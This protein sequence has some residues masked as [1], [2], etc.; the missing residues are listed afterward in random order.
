MDAARARREARYALEIHDPEPLASIEDVWTTASQMATVGIFLLL[1]VACLYFCRPILL[2]ILT[3]LLIGTTFA[4]VIKAANARGVSPWLSAIVLVLLG[5]TAAGISITMLAAPVSEWI[6]RAPEIG[7]SIKEKLYVFDRPLAAM[8][9]L[10]QVLMPSS[11]NAVAVESSQISGVVTPVLAFVT[12][13]VAQ[14][15]LFVACLVFFLAAQ[16]DARR[17]MVSLFASREGKLR[18]IR[19]ANDIEHNLASYVAVVSAINFCLG[20]IVALGTWIFGFSTPVLLGILAA[21]LNYIP[22]IGPA[23]MAVTLFGIGLVTFPTLGYA[24]LPPAAFVTLTTLEGHFITPTILGR[25]L[26]LNPLAV[27][28]ALAFWTWLWGPMGAFLAMP[29]LI[30]GLVITSHVLPSDDVKLPG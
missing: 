10:Q 6:G 16:V 2:P 21:L 13:A 5:L 19:I 18:T 20:V 1:L 28:L 11:G 26:T 29:L 7:A 17:Y 12:P 3:A 25:R 9:E 24:L 14:V 23:C 8:H 22:Y 4:P 15:V 27:F 30:V